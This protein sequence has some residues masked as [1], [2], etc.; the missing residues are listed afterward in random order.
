MMRLPIFCTFLALCLL[1]L[2]QAAEP[3]FVTEPYLQLGDAP[4]LSS[5]DS[6]V[7]M[8]H[9]ADVD[10]TWDVQVKKPDGVKWSG[11]IAASY[12]RVAVRGIEAH[13]VFR[14]Q[15]KGLTPGK[16]F[17]YRVRLD[18]EQVFQARARARK[19]KDQ[20]YRAVIFGDCAAGTPGSRA[21]AYQAYQAHPDFVLIPGDIVYSRGRISEYRLKYFPV[22]NAST[23]SPETGAPLLRS[24]LFIAAPGNHDIARPNLTLFPDSLAYFM[25]WS[26]PLNGPLAKIGDPSTP[27]F[28]AATEEEREAF[29]DSAS[30]SYPRMANFSFDYGNAHWTVL[31]SNPNVDWESAA[32]GDWLAK[33]LA[34]AKSA[35]WRFVAFHHPGFNSAEKH[36]NEQ[37]MR[38]L[39]AVFEAGGVDIVFS[40]HVHNYQRS[41]PMRFKAS[42]PDPDA[43]IKA[44]VGGEWTLDKKYDGATRTKPDGVIYLVTG[45][46]GAGVYNPEQQEF[47]L[48]WEPFTTKFFSIVNSF[49][50]VD[51]AGDKLT[52]RQITKDGEE[53]DHF[54]VT[55]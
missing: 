11:P 25:Y 45:A 31:D 34:S 18:G 42:P 26:Q 3:P 48:S 22:Y 43:K 19:S 55:R 27:V 23:A 16:D 51:A 36:F 35:S 2:G 33:D 8:W 12:T 1:C 29:L 50:V 44:R 10:R 40:G 47:P 52:I 30:E 46:G 49:T 53:V 41:F 9:A 6:M 15:I 28:V 21:V 7:V 54:V 17:D 37:G 39:S 32:F 5:S 14:A 4:R 20:P 38:R 13:R 24:T